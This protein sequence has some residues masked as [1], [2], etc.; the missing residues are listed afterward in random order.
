WLK[1]GKTLDD[2]WTMYPIGEEPTVHR[3]K[4]ADIDG[5]G[6]PAIILAP[7][8]GRGSSQKANWMDGRP[9]RLLAY[10]IPKDPVKGPGVR[11]VLNDN[12]HVVHNIGP[13]TD[14][15]GKPVIWCASY[16]GVT[17]LARDGAKWVSR[18]AGAGNQANPKGNRGASEIKVGKLKSGRHYVA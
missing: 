2:E 12:L 1:R 17:V 18:H 13:T 3:V 4:V 6:K 8:M 10:R 5:S 9:V 11:E 7:L 16:E 15:D 14:G